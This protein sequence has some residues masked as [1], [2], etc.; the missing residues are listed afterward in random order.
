MEHQR[1]PQKQFK[2]LEHHAGTLNFH[3]VCGE[4]HHGIESLQV[5]ATAS[6]AGHMHVLAADLQDRE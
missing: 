2:R 6:A 1:I 5:W 3:N 4:Y